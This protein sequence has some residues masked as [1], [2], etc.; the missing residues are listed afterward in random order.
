MERGR[1]PRQEAN[2]SMERTLRR[3]VLYLGVM[4]ILLRGCVGEMRGQVHQHAGH[5]LGT[6]NFPITCSEQ[7]QVSSIG[8]SPSCIT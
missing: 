6:V 7:A 5:P 4:L 1:L 3:V 8:R 2:K